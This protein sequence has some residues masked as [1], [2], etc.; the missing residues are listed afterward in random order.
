MSDLTNV[1]VR[2][3]AGAA[4][5][6][7]GAGTIARNRVTVNGAWAQHPVNGQNYKIVSDNRSPLD[8]R[9]VGFEN[10]QGTFNI[11]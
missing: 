6:N 10:N 8:G 1:T 7:N 3:Q 4:I 11:E 5:L 9:C 2:D